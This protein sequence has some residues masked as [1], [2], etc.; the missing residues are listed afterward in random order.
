MASLAQINDTQVS[1]INFK[2]VPVLT[3][4][5]LAGFYGTESVRIQQNHTRNKDR[6]IEGK[7][8]F[9]IIG[10]EL[11]DFVTSLKIVTNFPAI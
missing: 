9:K 8:F 4:E 1:I 3:S 5:Q 10:Q 11:K 7:H 2:S 6:F